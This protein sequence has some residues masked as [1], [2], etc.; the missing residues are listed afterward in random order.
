MKE[1][2]VVVELGNDNSCEYAD[3]VDRTDDVSKV[4]IEQGTISNNNES[5]RTT[6]SSTFLEKSVMEHEVRKS[7]HEGA[8][9]S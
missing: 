8:N 6:S 4:E 3:L 7:S 9:T 1:L 2:A 5:I